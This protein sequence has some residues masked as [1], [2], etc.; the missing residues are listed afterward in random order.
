MAAT[1]TRECS[2]V[3]RACSR[4]KQVSANP[5]TLAQ[6]LAAANELGSYTKSNTTS[7]SSKVKTVTVLVCTACQPGFALRRTDPYPMRCDCAPGLAPDGAGGCMP[8]PKGRFCSGPVKTEKGVVTGSSDPSA[9]PFGL[10]TITQGARSKMQCMTLPGYGRKSNREPGTGTLALESEL[11]SLGTYNS[12]GNTGGCQQCG[13]AMTTRSEGSAKKEE[14]VAPK[15]HFTY[16]GIAKKCQKG[17]YSSDFND[18][19]FC[20]KCPKGMTTTDEG[21]IDAMACSYAQRG[22][23]VS[24]NGEG[25][26]CPVDTYNDAERMDTSCIVCP[27]GLKTETTGSEGVAMCLAPPGWELRE[28]EGALTITP[29]RLGWYKDGWNKNPCVPCG[30]NIDTDGEGTPSIDGCFI[31]PGYGSVVDQNGIIRAELC[32]E[33]RFGYNGRM[34]Q[35]Q[36]AFCQACDTNTFTRDVLTGTPAA[37][38]YT[39]P[40][41]CLVMPG[42]GIDITL[43]AV[44]CKIGTYNEG[45]NRK[46]CQPCPTLFTTLWER[47]NSSTHCVIKPGWAM[48]TALNLPKPCDLGSFSA[49]GSLADPGCVCRP[50]PP[51]YTTQTDQSIAE[52]ECNVCIAGH[53]SASCSYCPYDTFSTGGHHTELNCWPCPAGTTSS[54]MAE[55]DTRCLATMV[56]ADNDYFPLSDETKWMPQA[57]VESGMV[58]NRACDDSAAC[59]LYRFSSNVNGPPACQ[60]LLEDPAGQQLIGLKAG[61]G[62]DYVMYTID[63]NLAV[64][65]L[66]AEHADKT[67]EQ[68][69]AA[70]A[71]NGCELVS[72]ALPNMPDAPGPCKLYKSVSDADWVGMHHVQGNKLFSDGFVRERIP[73]NTIIGEL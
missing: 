11:C 3:H 36:S 18:Q 2:T 35:I 12:G 9:C 56:D 44:P 27:F 57:G 51:G 61:G 20:T 58:C 42:W 47:A 19:S 63:E 72:M 38:G 60:L 53:G 66:L 5:D 4:C 59:I 43:T 45:L 14:C 29:C 8:C 13:N 67:P 33:N 40:E 30:Q 69:M 1:A 70:C 64:G 16:N 6:Q 71:T 28:W 24:T 46:L 32:V 55:D 7:S 54:R 15:G 21:S 62:M 23:F 10:T 34:Y 49:G 65:V 22:M 52:W 31:P 39:V 68:C 25:V 41:D 17:T 26:E 50:C 73:G 37:A 48:D